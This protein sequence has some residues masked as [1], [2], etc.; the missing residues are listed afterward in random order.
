MD[1]VLRLKI[2]LEKETRRLAISP[3]VTFEKL[4]VVVK[5][6]KLEKDFPIRYE[7]D[8]GELVT[9]ASDEDL[10][11]AVYVMQEANQKFLK[12]YVQESSNAR[13]SVSRERSIAKPVEIQQLKSGA[14]EAVAAVQEDSKQSENWYPSL[15]NVEFAFN[16]PVQ[17]PVQ[18]AQ[19]AEDKSEPVN[20]SEEK[21]EET[22]FDSSLRYLVDLAHSIEGNQEIKFETIFIISS[23]ISYDG[24]T[25]WDAFTSAITTGAPFTSSLPCF[26]EPELSV[27]LKHLNVVAKFL[28]EEVESATLYPLPEHI[29]VLMSV[30]SDSFFGKFLTMPGMPERVR[31]ILRHF[32]SSVKKFDAFGPSSAC[33]QADTDLNSIVHPNVACDGCGISPIRGARYKCQACPNFDLCEACEAKGTH[34]MDHEMIKFKRPVQNY[35]APFGKGM[36]GFPE[37]HHPR[38]HGHHGHGVQ[39]HGYRRKWKHSKCPW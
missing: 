20:Q 26:H 35:F 15:E 2:V 16:Q 17:A 9:L 29:G 38:H 8:E 28:D 21:G 34:P 22:S 5:G 7:D 4:Q 12:L 24:F 19:V 3:P 33:P 25:S 14:P 32:A 36:F 18:Q 39:H 1:S 23:F 13:L 30:L 10:A 31:N 37:P 6:F 11:E 27:L